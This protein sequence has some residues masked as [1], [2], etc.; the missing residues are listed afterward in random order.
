[1][2]YKEAEAGRSTMLG[3]FAALFCVW[4][5][6]RITSCVTYDRDIGGHLKRAGDANS[7]KLAA[8]ELKIAIDNIDKWGLCPDVKEVTDPENL[9]GSCYTSILYK[10]PS[11]DIAFWRFNLQEAHADLLRLPEDADTLMKSN[12]LMKLRETL[13]DNG[14]KGVRVTNPDGISIYPRNGIYLWFGLLSALSALVILGYKVWH[15]W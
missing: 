14:E 10:T 7:V 4:A 5:V 1:M 6:I 9:P 11:E 8:S 13:L 3:I 12:T 2:G 15:D